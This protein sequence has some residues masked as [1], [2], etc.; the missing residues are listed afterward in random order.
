MFKQ[1]AQEMQMLTYAQEGV[2]LLSSAFN[3]LF[4]GIIDGSKNM[5]EILSSIFKQIVSQILQMI[6]RLIAMKIVMAIIGGPLG[7]IGAGAGLGNM[8]AIAPLIGGGALAYRGGIVPPGYPNDSYPARLSSGEAI[9]P[10]D[11]INSLNL[12]PTTAI[13]EGEV[14]F[15]IEGETLVGILQKRT[16]K[17][18]IF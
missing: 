10:L 17:S 14:R 7:A 12:Q 15:E 8:P 3:D 13:L 6:A 16:K 2:D 11:N 1:L 5:G 18:N 9:V 4:Q